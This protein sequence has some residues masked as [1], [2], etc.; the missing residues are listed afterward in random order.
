MLIIQSISS[1]HRGII[2]SFI[3]VSFCTV[4][5]SG[6][7][8]K[9]VFVRKGSPQVPPV[10]SRYLRNNIFPVH[11]QIRELNSFPSDWK[12]ERRPQPPAGSGPVRDL[13]KAGQ[14]KE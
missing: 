4:I 10:Q 14:K 2:E 7:K 9:I 13:R 3:L 1:Y 6:L 11:F 5:D 8:E 12:N